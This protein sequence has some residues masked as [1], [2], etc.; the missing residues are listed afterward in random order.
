MP[1]R[2]EP[3]KR[4]RHILNQSVEDSLSNQIDSLYLQGT[5]YLAL[6]SKEDK[7]SES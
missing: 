5:Y 3:L 2:L 7:S 1:L 6:T 4:P